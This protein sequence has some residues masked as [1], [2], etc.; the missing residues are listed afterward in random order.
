MFLHKMKTKWKSNRRLYAYMRCIK[1]LEPFLIICSWPHCL[2]AVP[3][4][5]LEGLS[6]TFIDGHRFI[7][8]VSA[9]I[10][11]FIPIL[12]LA[13]NIFVLNLSSSNLAIVGCLDNSIRLFTSGGECYT[14]TRPSRGDGNK[15]GFLR[16]VIR[17]HQSVLAQ[18]NGLRKCIFSIFYMSDTFL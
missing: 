17:L 2:Q 8:V 11:N 16:V 5:L 3:P 15:I 14:R 13:S 9:Y 1:V 6:N 4:G 12:H 7:A 18:N 10:L